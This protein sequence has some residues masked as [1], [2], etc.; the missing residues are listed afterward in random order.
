MTETELLELENQQ[1]RERIAQLE[2]QLKEAYV[3]LKRARDPNQ[4]DRPSFKRV[5]FLAREACMNL[6]RVRGGWELSIGHLKRKFRR[7]L[8]IWKILTEEDWCLSDIF[9]VAPKAVAS[10]TLPPRH[11]PTL[12]KQEMR[13]HEPSFQRLPFAEK[14]M[15]RGNLKIADRPSRVATFWNR[16]EELPDRDVPF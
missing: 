1:L 8:E 3:S 11:N 9:E 15:E 6:Q 10:V 12:D 4:L 13:Q 7:L 16:R 5:S 14:S 2:L